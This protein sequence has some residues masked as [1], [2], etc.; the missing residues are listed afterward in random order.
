MEAEHGQPMNETVVGDATERDEL[1]NI[2]R[3]SAVAQIK[4]EVMRNV[5]E[6]LSG[7]QFP[8]FFGYL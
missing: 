4:V 1:I 5:I 6:R 3:E 8:R 2:R 7:K